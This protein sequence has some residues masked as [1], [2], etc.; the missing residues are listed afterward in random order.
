ML[1]LGFWLPILILHPASG[2]PRLT[3]PNLLADF[4]NVS[5]TELRV[6]DFLLLLRRGLA[7]VALASISWILLLQ[8]ANQAHS[9][10]QSG[11][12]NLI[13]ILADDK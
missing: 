6:P 9:A 5:F 1:T 8:T 12:P 3:E 2:L 11:G 4:S 13:F 10:E 7:P